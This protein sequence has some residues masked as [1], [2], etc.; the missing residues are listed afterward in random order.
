MRGRIACGINHSKVR[1][2]EVDQE[3]RHVESHSVSI[4][5]NLEHDDA[6][7]CVVLTGVDRFT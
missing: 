3:S 6:K 1:W 4:Q 5:G 7:V 2:I